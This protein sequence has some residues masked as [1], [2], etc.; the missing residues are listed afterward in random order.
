MTLLFPVTASRK[1]QKIDASP[2]RI[3]FSTS[4][5]IVTLSWFCNRVQ[6]VSDKTLVLAFSPQKPN[7]LLTIYPRPVKL[8]EWLR[9][10]TL[11]LTRA[12][13]Q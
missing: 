9:G 5:L 4:R 7:K 6:D 10:A 2:E 11:Y 8:E 1:T 12:P 13:A 3:F